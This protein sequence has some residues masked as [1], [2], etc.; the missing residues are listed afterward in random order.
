MANGTSTT[1]IK[2]GKIKIDKEWIECIELKTNSPNL[3]S[4]S[5]LIS[6]GY[7]EIFTPEKSLLLP[8]VISMNHDTKSKL[9][10]LFKK[11]ERPFDH[12]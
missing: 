4:L 10:E 9:K 11:M 7:T 3:L 8:P 1:N 12:N 5:Q 6:K 2:S